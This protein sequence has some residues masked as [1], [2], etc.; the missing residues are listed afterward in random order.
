MLTTAAWAAALS[1]ARFPGVC[2][3]GHI[4]L[5]LVGYTAGLRV[6]WMEVR[7]TS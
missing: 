3:K 7:S 1:K 4:R 2:G 5:A 6:K